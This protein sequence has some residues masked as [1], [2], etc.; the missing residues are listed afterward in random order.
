MSIDLTDD[1]TLDTVL[2]CSDCGE[3]MRYNYQSEGFNELE[4]TTHDPYEAFV[5]WAIADAELEH[6]CE[7]Y[8]IDGERDT[9]AE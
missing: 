8:L 2:R 9:S 3:E 1:G 7:N 6:C 4:A 5:E